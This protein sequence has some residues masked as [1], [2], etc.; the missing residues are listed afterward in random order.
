MA[1]N[2]SVPAAEGIFVFYVEPE[3]R[4]AVKRALRDLLYVPFHFESEGASIIYYS[5]ESYEFSERTEQ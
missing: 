5:P 2:F 1:A 3:K 4:A